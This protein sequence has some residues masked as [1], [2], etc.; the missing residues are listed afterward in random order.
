[1]KRAVAIIMGTIFIGLMLTGCVTTQS[2][3]PKVTLNTIDIG[4]IKSAIIDDLKK[5]NFK[6]VSDSNDVL[7][8]EGR[9]LGSTG[10]DLMHA[11]LKFENTGGATTVI[12]QAFQKSEA[13]F[14]RNTYSADLT[15]SNEGAILLQKLQKIKEQV[16]SK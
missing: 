6:V 3:Q 2:G 4:K 16:E 9:K 15:Y 14:S 5:S 11:I 10:S 12:M 8:L 1:M 7:I 13:G